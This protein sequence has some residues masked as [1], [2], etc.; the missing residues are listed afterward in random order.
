MFLSKFKSD[1]IIDVPNYYVWQ[2]LK[3]EGLISNK[4]N[5]DDGL[6]EGCSGTFDFYVLV[7]KD[8]SNSH[9]EINDKILY[10]KFIDGKIGLKNNISIFEKYFYKSYIY[11][12]IVDYDEV[13]NNYII[14]I[15]GNSVYSHFYAF[16]FFGLWIRL[17]KFWYY[18]ILNRNDY[19]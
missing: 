4:V 11:G 10:K 19:D 17:Y 3:E 18:V 5:Y 2:C 6:S 7:N 14:N 12:T 9:W 1:I 15:R 16:V 8:N 13:N